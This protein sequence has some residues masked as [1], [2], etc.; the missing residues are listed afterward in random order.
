MMDGLPDMTLLAH[1]IRVSSRLGVFTSDNG[2]NEPRRE[3]D[4][5][6]CD[7]CKAIS[8]RVLDV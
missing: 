6:H 8:S 7:E 4:F 3:N 5:R 2:E 1:K